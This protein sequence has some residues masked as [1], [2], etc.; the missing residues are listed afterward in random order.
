[1]KHY[2]SHVDWTTDSV[3]QYCILCKGLLPYLRNPFGRDEAGCFNKRKASSRQLVYQL[4]LYIGRHDGLHE[5]ERAQGGGEKRS[6]WRKW[7]K[8]ERSERYYIIY[9]SPFRSAAHLS[10][11]P[12]QPSLY[13]GAQPC[14]T[15]CVTV[16]VHA[17]GEYIT[18]QPPLQDARDDTPATSPFSS[19]STTHLVQ[20]PIQQ[21]ASANSTHLAFGLI[22]VYSFPFPRSKPETWNREPTVHSSPGPSHRKLPED[23]ARQSPYKAF[24]WRVTHYLPLGVRMWLMK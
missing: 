2:K 18:C 14:L 9:P 19:P 5:R 11:P 23:E 8:E 12:P 7:W 6:S 15:A 13:S 24:L 20:G 21:L 22:A 1:M 3:W 16:R 4:N 17:R 10:V